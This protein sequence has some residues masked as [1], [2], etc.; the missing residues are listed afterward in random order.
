MCMF[1]KKKIFLIIAI[2]MLF[3][4]LMPGIPTALGY[5]DESMSPDELISDFMERNR[6]NENNF[7]FS[8]Y[9]TVTGETH[10]FNEDRLMYAAS[11]YKLPLAMYYY[12]ES[13]AGNIPAN[14][15]Y[16]GHSLADSLRLSLLYSDNAT[17]Q[18]MRAAMGSYREHKIALDKYTGV[19]AAE[20]GGN[21][22]ITHYYS[23]AMILNVLK[24]LHNDSEF[25]SEGIGYLKAANPGQFFRM[26]VSDYEIAQ[27]YGYWEASVNTA[28][29]VY[30]PTPY[31]LCV[32]TEKLGN[33]AAV[34]GRFNEMMCDYTVAKNHGWNPETMVFTAPRSSDVFIN[35]ESVVFETYNIG[36]INFLK[37]RDIA[38]VLNGTDKQFSVG[39]DD[40]EKTIMLTS[41][42]EYSPVEGDMAHGGGGGRFAELTAG[43]VYLDGKQLDFSVYKIGGSHFIGIRDFGSAIGFKVGW[44]SETGSITIVTGG[45]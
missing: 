22:L 29:I 40:A 19:S 44:N 33:A 45:V 5:P 10:M 11:V 41:G 13:A 4:M 28:G 6:L 9:N 37:L 42:T 36:G 20:V 38:Y 23:T 16:A 24:Y 1:I 43:I 34:I 12:E 18:A 32:F 31:L 7:A 2:V 35:G 15:R 14:R 39:Y 25:F 30:T 8:Y 26:Y 17:A 27:K 21:Y 3:A